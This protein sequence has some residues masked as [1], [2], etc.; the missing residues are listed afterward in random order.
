MLLTPGERVLFETKPTLLGLYWGRL[1]LLVLLDL[2]W[3]AVAVGLPTNPTGGLFTA[4]TTL[5]LVYYV[6]KWRS[7]A[8]ALTNRRVLSVVGIRQPN[9]T[10]ALLDQVRNLRLEPGTSGGIKFDATPPDAPTTF[11]GTRKF[12]KTIYWRALPLASRTYEFVQQAFALQSVQSFHN[13]LRADLVERISQRA[14]PCEYCGT[15]VDLDTVDPLKPRCP[16]CGAPFVPIE[17]Q[18]AATQARLAQSPSL[19]SPPRTPP[20]I[21]P[22]SS[23]IYPVGTTP[24]PARTSGSAPSPAGSRSTAPPSVRPSPPTPAASSPNAASS[25]PGTSTERE[26]HHRRRDRRA[27][28]VPGSGGWLLVLAILIVTSAAGIGSNPIT[29]GRYAAQLTP[30]ITTNGVSP[31]PTVGAA[32]VFDAADGYV[33]MF[34]GLD[35]AGNAVPWTWSFVHNNWTNL[36]GAVG[37][38]PSARWGEGLAYDARDGYVVLFGGCRNLACTEVVNDTWIY[39]QD[40][41]ANV[42]AEQTNPPAARG[43]TM[44]T[45]DVYDHYVLLFG[46]SS[47]GGV[48]LN[49]EWAFFAGTWATVGN[50][51]SPRPSARAGAM[52]AYDPSTSSAIL[53]GGFT[54]TSSLGDTW[55]YQNGSWT[56]LSSGAGSSPGPRRLG[57]MT[58]DATDGY[59]ML[60]NG[61]NNGYLDDEWTFSSGAWAELTTHGRPVP[62]F[63]AVLVYDSVDRYVLYFS[64]EDAQGILTSTLIYSNGNWTLLINP[65]Y[66]GLTPL[67]IA[68]LAVAII[69]IP[70]AL[71]AYA[72]SRLRRRQE[73]LLGEGFLLPPGER[74]T[75]IPTGSALRSRNLQQLVILVAF[76]PVLAVAVVAGAGGGPAGLVALLLVLPIFGV[77]MGFAVW[78]SATQ[79]VRTVGVARSGVILSRRAGELR[80]PWSQLQPGVMPPRRG[81]YWF[82]Y[83]VPGKSVA[84]RGFLATVQQAR[85]I[86]SSPFAPPWVLTSAVATGLGLPPRATSAAPGPAGTLAALPLGFPPPPT[87]AIPSESTAPG[88]APLAS[89]HPMQPPLPP[90]PPAPTF[91]TA[92]TP[93]AGTPPTGYRSTVPVPPSGP[94]GAASSASARPPPGMTSCPNCGQLNAAGRVAFCTA[95]GTRLR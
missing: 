44:M 13:G 49:D 30:S 16:S 25:L 70:I 43:R 33:L 89:G 90:S 10:E 75:W 7:S 72:G 73:R 54:A 82:Q 83:I 3:I 15:M 74:P 39:A 92:Q 18:R 9:L 53:F 6:L 8:Y 17:I 88:P 46:G 77:L 24:P 26:P 32:A 42:T 36:S 68:L 52:M 11:L 35:A 20:P 19:P 51:S 59:L 21:P 87:G 56:N 14:I 78:V 62:T 34:G 79:A 47:T 5:V 65:T 40:R 60:V 84:S 94:P 85:T 69:G 95:C 50:L 12:A 93:A 22:F 66:P 29:D 38:A 4:I 45:Y 31:A 80:I 76:V 58:Y 55:S 37:L 23:A 41:W 86:L 64:G 1:T 48:L 61:Y 27:A 63:G 57:M 91:A 2:L 67:G 71:A 81:S 28:G